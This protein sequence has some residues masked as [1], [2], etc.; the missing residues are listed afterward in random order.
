MADIVWEDGEPVVA[1]PRQILR[2][3]LERLA[4]RG[5]EAM[6][7][8]EL[9]FIL[10]RNS[11]EDAWR[12]GFRDLEPAQL[13]QH[14]LLAA[15]HGAG[16]AADP[17]HPQLD[18]RR[19]HDRRSTRRASATSASTRS[20]STSATPCAPPTS[21]RSTRTAPRR[22]P[23][24]DGMAITFMA[25]WDEREGN[26]C[27]IHLSLRGADDDGIVF[28][29]DALFERFVAGQLAGLRELTLFLAPNVNSYK[30]FVPG[31]FAPT[32]VAWGHDNRTCS[33]RV[34]GHGPS[35]RVENRLPGRGR[36]PLPGHQ[37]DGRG[38]PARDRLRA[39]ARAGVR[40]QRL[41]GR[42]AARAGEPAR[43]ARAV[44]RRASWR[45]RPSARRW[46]TIT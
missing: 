44:R 7:G 27:H 36:Q 10:F 33:L 21:T 31:S 4:E 20:T 8:T 25:K 19:G 43:G 35:R 22:W 2:R 14:R 17:P 32:A 18:G 39:R 29:D 45:A 41:R 13:L 5:W 30:R 42:Q 3:Q 37:R 34:V 9:E 23:P 24:Q 46:S 40:G 12:R 11:Y 38:R 6:C 15:G 16:R 28:D 26:S 1:S